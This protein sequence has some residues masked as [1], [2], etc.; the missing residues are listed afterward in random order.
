MHAKRINS[1]VGSVCSG[2]KIK[3][4]FN[5]TKTKHIQHKEVPHSKKATS[6]AQ[7]SWNS[8]KVKTSV[9]N[10]ACS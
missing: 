7:L 9:G 1:C 4:N 8:C 10:L 2:L 3:T 5:D 6:A